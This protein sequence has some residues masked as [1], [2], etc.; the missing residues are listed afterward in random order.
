MASW[1]GLLAGCANL[2]LLFLGKLDLQSA[3]VLLQTVQI[4]SAWNWEDVISLSHEP[5]ESKLTRR[6]VL[7]LGDGSD[8]VDELQVLREI[9]GRGQYFSLS[10]VRFDLVLPLC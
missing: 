4:G 3:N 7:L 5:R 10:S 1:L 6:C 9:L 8:G 2:L